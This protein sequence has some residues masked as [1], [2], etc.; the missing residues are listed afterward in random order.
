MFDL[1][2]IIANATELARQSDLDIIRHHPRLQVV[3]GGLFLLGLLCDVLLLTRRPIIS[4]RVGAKPWG[5]GEVVVAVSLLVIGQLLLQ[6]ILN[7]AHTD[8]EETWALALFGNLALNLVLLAALAL[9][10]RR[11]GITLREAFGFTA[12]APLTGLI[13]YLAVLPPVVVAM[14][15]TQLC[16]QALR[17]EL[18]PQ[19]VADLF[20]TTESPDILILVAGLAIVVAPVFEEVFFRGFLYPVLKAKW[21]MPV[22]LA[23][24]SLV[25]AAIHLHLP[26][27]APLFLL[28]L[29]LGLVY[30]R[31]GSL[32]ASITLHSL[33]NTAN[34]LMLFYLRHHA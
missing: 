21:G 26:S 27:T 12:S 30:E 15:I 4:D 5:R 17:I 1:S 23:T 20:L 29:A 33:F 22:A 13:G 6:V 7:F 3:A 19:P 34:I 25:F 9:Y 2:P 32:L 14:G 18:T 28:G 16:Y 31:S 11:R 24:V 10:L 8:G